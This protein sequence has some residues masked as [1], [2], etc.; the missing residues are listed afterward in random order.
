MTHP[1]SPAGAIPAP[2]SGGGMA[3]TPSAS[4]RPVQGPA[5]QGASSITPAALG[6]A[7]MVEGPHLSTTPGGG[8]GR[9][10]PPSGAT[11]DLTAALDERWE[12]E[13]E[14][15][16]TA[17]R[18]ALL[19]GLLAAEQVAAIRLIDI[20]ELRQRLAAAERAAAAAEEAN[21]ELT[22][23]LMHDRL[24]RVLSRDGLVDAVL[25][26][27][28]DDPDRERH[29]LLLDLD[30][31]KRVNDTHG[32]GAGDHVLWLT[33]Q[34][35]AACV[36]G[37]DESVARLAGDEYAVLVDGDQAAAVALAERIS[38]E[39]ARPVDVEPGVPVAVTA[40]IGVAQLDGS[41]DGALRHADVA[42]YWAKSSSCGV[43]S[44]RPDMVMPPERVGVRRRVRGAP[45]CS[46][47]GAGCPGCMAGV[48]A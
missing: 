30:G 46:C 32:H 9:S 42:M 24:T 36:P 11:P 48:A 19:A 17:P 1:T 44:W 16:S 38:A 5:A 18:E 2:A 28:L 12:A 13:A 45:P 10:T 23:L 43:T 4:G 15:L 31:F 14:A 20:A 40:S 39:V 6:G 7:A 34:R 8:V 21:D 37:P 3:L 26:A 41:L 25:R 47:F 22:D 33:A 35:I 27:G 29:L